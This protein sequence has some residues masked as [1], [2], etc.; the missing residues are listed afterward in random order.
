MALDP[1][2]QTTC[3]VPLTLTAIRGDSVSI[4]LRLFGAA[5][6]SPIALT[7]Y[8]GTASV[9]ATPNQGLPL[10]SLTV[11]VDQA[12][13]SMPT[14][15][16]VTVSLAGGASQVWIEDGYWALVL[17]DGTTRK[18]LISGPWQLRGPAIGPAA[19]VCGLCPTPGAAFDLAGA[20]CGILDGGYTRIVLPFPASSCGC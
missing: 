1:I 3:P 17:E 2:A 9:Y 4:P 19:F 15:G 12:A 6:G 16:V 14:T 10:H 18:T 7:G 11:V 5:T 20:G 13:A 8:S